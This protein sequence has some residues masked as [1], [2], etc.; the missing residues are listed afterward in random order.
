MDESIVQ[1]LTS[2]GYSAAAARTA[3]TAVG[4]NALNA[5][6]DWISTPRNQDEI[7]MA[8]AMAMSME[9]DQDASSSSSSSLSADAAAAA[10][11]ADAADASEAAAAASGNDA[12]AG[13]SMSLLDKSHPAWKRDVAKAG[14]A[15]SLTL[16]NLMHTQPPP[17][18]SSSSEGSPLF[19]MASLLTRIEASAT[20]RLER[21]YGCRG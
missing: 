1:Q 19:R 9:V 17:S 20:S 11:V 21:L 18:S 4:S 10:A 7:E 2:F 13:P 14:A 5:A 6:M 8:E 3:L 16:L 15:T 12:E